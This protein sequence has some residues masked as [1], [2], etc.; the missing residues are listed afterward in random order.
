MIER[1]QPVEIA[2][3]LASYSLEHANDT[4]GVRAA[5]ILFAMQCEQSLADVV[6]GNDEPRAVS[7]VSLIGHAGGKKTL[8]L[9]LPKLNSST[10]S[11]AVRSAA[12][13]ALGRRLD[14]QR[15][16]LELVEKQELAKELQFAAANA[17]L[18]SSDETIAQRASKWLTLPATADSKPLPPLSE[19]V[20]QRGNATKGADIFRTTGTCINCHKLRG[21]G[22]EVGPDLSEIGSK[23]SREA[24]YTSILDPSAAVSHNF[25]T[26]QLLTI[27]GDAITGL[28]IS[29]TD[30]AITLRNAE[31][32]DKTFSKDEVEVFQKQK[33]SLM[34]QDLQR[35]LTVEQLKDL[36]EYTLTL[37][38]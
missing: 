16:I 15:A 11:L 22:K 36:V 1:F 18:S 25:E 24:M 34:P 8:E 19:L 35:L 13:T 6:E 10:L 2:E 37:T 27:D 28:L 3:Q 33:I 14:G 17:L 29:E 12:V 23:L 4:R 5:E 32:I 20:K 31:G 30:A 7:A 9:L 21:E 38:K 26:Y